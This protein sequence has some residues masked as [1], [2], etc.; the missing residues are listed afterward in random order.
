MEK[1]YLSYIKQVERALDLPQRQKKELL[2]GFQVELNERF[3]ETPSFDRLLAD[4]GQPEEV[5][6][7]LLEAVGTKNYIRF[8]FIRLRYF[9]ITIITL[10]L[11]IMISIGMII[12]LDASEFKRVEKGIIEDSIPTHYSVPIGEN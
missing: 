12:Y 11:L 9:R 6:S 10:V 2:R 7:A 8:N 5:A 3:S 1:S 4:M